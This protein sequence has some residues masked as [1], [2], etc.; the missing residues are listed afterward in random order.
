M[1]DSLDIAESTLEEQTLREMEL[2]SSVVLENSLDAFIAINTK[3]KIIRWNQQATETFGWSE[4]EVKGKSLDQFIVPR[5]K[6]T[7]YRKGIK[8]VL[9][10]GESHLLNRRIEIDA[11]HRDGHTFPVEI[12][13]TPVYSGGEIISFSAF[14]RDITEN[15]NL[16]AIHQAELIIL[17]MIATGKP[18]KH[19]LTA[20][21]KE[22]EKLTPSHTV[23]SVLLVNE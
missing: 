2:L 11:Q 16:E 21:C 18:Q 6:K 22:I 5:G 13:I 12:T 7:A 4:N 15:K 20:L 19:I 8:R 23:V 1:D 17:E 9:E 14:I 3:G 10:T